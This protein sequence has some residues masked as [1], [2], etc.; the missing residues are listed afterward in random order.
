[1]EKSKNPLI[2]HKSPTATATEPQ[3]HQ[4]P[5]ATIINQLIKITRERGERERVT[6]GL[7][8]TEGDGVG[9]DGRQRRGTRRT[10]T[11]WDSTDG[12]GVVQRGEEMGE[13]GRKKEKENG[14]E[15]RAWERKGEREKRKEKK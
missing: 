12:D 2:I 1:M 9:V 10:A 4:S 3:N 8:S 6:G 5:T 15:E 13:E 7:Y 11:A 14:E